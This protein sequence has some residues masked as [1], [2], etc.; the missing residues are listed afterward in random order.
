M[1]T[2]ENTTNAPCFISSEIALGSQSFHMH[3]MLSQKKE[4]PYGNE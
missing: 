4:H 3:G 1:A 2:P